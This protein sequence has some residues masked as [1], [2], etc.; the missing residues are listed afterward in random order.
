MQRME[1]DD[2]RIFLAVARARGLAGGARA[3]GLDRSTASRRVASL[4]AALGARLFL[5]TREGLRL[6]VAGAA[7]VERAERMA[8][9]AKAIEAAA[10]STS[11]AVRGRVRLATTESLATMLVRGGLLELASRHPALEIELLAENRVVD[12]AR[13]EADLALRVARVQE[14]SL[15]V[16]RVAR[17]PFA[18]FASE[19]YLTR[20]RDR[21]RSE[22]D[23]AGHDAITLG[24][25]LAS[26]PEAKWLAAHPE[27]RVVLRTTGVT[28]LLAA[29]IDGHG[30]AVISGMWGARD[31]GLSRLFA[32]DAIAPRPL[33]LAM[34]PDTAG[35]AAVRAVA[36]HVAAIARRGEAEAAAG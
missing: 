34:H 27:A 26:L 14:P 4:E 16:K 15:R 35:R 19:T 24:G 18:L 28:A 7:L 30:V 11:D 5:R 13:G 17:L 29:V 22:R 1:W 21:P 20:R 32:I 9:E 6:S 3:V 23:L 31:L 8:A 10:A 33:W 12:L 2:V 36:T 25:T